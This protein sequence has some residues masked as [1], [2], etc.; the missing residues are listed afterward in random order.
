MVITKRTLDF[1]LLSLILLIFLAAIF[2]IFYYFQNQKNACVSNPLVFG[3]KQLTK[4]SGYEFFGTGYFRVPLDYK[5]PIIIFNSTTI[6][7]QK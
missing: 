7:I 6:T 3:S 1:L 5:S 2:L 4:A